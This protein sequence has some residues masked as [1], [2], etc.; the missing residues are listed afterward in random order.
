MLLSLVIFIPSTAR[1]A[2]LTEQQKIVNY[3]HK[4]NAELD[5]TVANELAVAMLKQQAKHGI[6]VEIQLSIV[7]RESRFEQ[8]AM[9]EQGELGFFQIMIKPHADKVLN[10]SRA[11]E[12]KTKNIYNP[13]TQATV[14]MQVLANCLVKKQRDM[15]RALACYNGAM[16]PGEYS[17]AVIA[18]ASTIKKIL[19][20][21]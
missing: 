16:H 2:E 17:D 4:V 10:M 8:F 14:A 5:N 3:M 13:D 9:G 19:N 15:H 1:A 6:P 12:I 20:R 7:R 18:K 11:K 21:A